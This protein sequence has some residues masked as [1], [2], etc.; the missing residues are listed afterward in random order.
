[1]IGKLSEERVLAPSLAKNGITVYG[2]LG[3]SCCLELIQF[4]MLHSLLCG[5]T[6]YI[7][8]R[9]PHLQDLHS[10]VLRRQAHVDGAVEAARAQECIV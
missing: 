9:A 3:I 7:M 4:L 10:L 2:E 8:L 1:M 6:G 5:R